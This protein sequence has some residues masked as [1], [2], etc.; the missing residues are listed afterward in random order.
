MQ[1]IIAGVIQ[2]SIVRCN[3]L[4]DYSTVSEN[5]VQKSIIPCFNCTDVM[6]KLNRRF[7]RGQ[8]I[9]VY[10][11]RKKF[12]MTAKRNSKK[13]QKSRVF[14]CLFKLN[15]AKKCSEIKVHKPL[16]LGLSK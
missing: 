3:L 7:R 1:I 2:Y 13:K 9:A 15:K 5:T 11:H 14:T 4:K 8:E 12:K 10:R 6:A 16:T